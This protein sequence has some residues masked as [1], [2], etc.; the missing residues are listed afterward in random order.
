M[1][2]RV[3]PADGALRALLDRAKL[4]LGL[5]EGQWAEWQ[6]QNSERNAGLAQHEGP[7]LDQPEVR[8]WPAPSP[9]AR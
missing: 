7:G 4:E 2:Q 1:L 9:L 5:Y 3:R 6:R 8:A